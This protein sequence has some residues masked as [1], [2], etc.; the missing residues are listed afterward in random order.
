MTSWQK[1]D[2]C[3]KYI[4]GQGAIDSFCDCPNEAEQFKKV[5]KVYDEIKECVEEFDFEDGADAW[6]TLNYISEL[7]RGNNETH[8]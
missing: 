4:E 5:Q 1:C 8:D 3:K 2:K 7:F 6:H